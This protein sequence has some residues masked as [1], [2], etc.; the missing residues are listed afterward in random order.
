MALFWIVV[1]IFQSNENDTKFGLC[2]THAHV[3]NGNPMGSRRLQFFEPV[4]AVA[5]HQ[6]QR[7]AVAWSY[8]L[9]A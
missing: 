8:S 7:L 4:A 6:L 3:D 5:F 2:L 1:K 9:L